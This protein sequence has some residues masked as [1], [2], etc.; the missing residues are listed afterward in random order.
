M[1]CKELIEYLSG[2][3]PDSKVGILEINPETREAHYA[4]TY[5]LLTDAGGA[6]MFFELGDAVPLDDIAEEVEAAP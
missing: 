4:K 3:E 5:Q 6:V 2:F 1:T